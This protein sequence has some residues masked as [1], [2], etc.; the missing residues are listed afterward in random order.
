MR[1]QQVYTGKAL[2]FPDYTIGLY[3]LF[4]A[5]TCGVE[6]MDTPI[7]ALLDTASE[8]CVLP[9]NVARH[10]GFDLTAG[11]PPMRLET[12]LGT[13]SGRLERV[14]IQFL[15]EVGETM[16][17]QATC[18]VSQDWPGPLVIGWKGCLERMRFALDPGED[19]FYFAGL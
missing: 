18:F 17:M 19:T 15:A 8:W 6:K 4:I 12:R 16:E 3:R 11:S 1:L 2:S 14:E 10:L 9:A 5:V 13:V 7:R